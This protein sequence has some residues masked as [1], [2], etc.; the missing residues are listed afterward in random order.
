MVKVCRDFLGFE[1]GMS[2]CCWH[3]CGIG[4]NG[5]P[6]CIHVN[7]RL[8]YVFVL[9][10]M[11]VPYRTDISFFPSILISVFLPFFQFRVSSETLLGSRPFLSFLPFLPRLDV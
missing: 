9:N 2:C 1:S 6:A 4:I 11:D 5:V 3:L 7:E 8:Q 10:I